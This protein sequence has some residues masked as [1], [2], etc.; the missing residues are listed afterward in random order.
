MKRVQ[1]RTD[2][3]TATGVVLK[4]L[5]SG[6]T[7]TLNKL[8]NETSLNFR[9]VKKVLDLLEKCQA[10]LLEKKID[11]S[12]LDNLTIIQMRERSGMS[13]LPEKVRRLVI[14]ASYYPTVSR[15]E[16]ILTYL[17]AH[18]ATETNSRIRIDKDQTLTKLL[19]AGHVEEKSGKFYL[20]N[21]GKIVANGALTLYPEL[22]GTT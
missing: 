18:N 21:M 13:S 5:E 1:T 9:T 6:E 16:E 14:K 2:L 8:S 19:K 4:T 3:S 20:T 11:I 10:I 12:N 17:L 22:K 7:F 15:E